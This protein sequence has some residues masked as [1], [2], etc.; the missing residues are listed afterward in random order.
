M[1]Y[2]PLNPG[3]SSDPTA[4]GRAYTPLPNS[5]TRGALLFMGYLG[6]CVCVCVYTAVQRHS[7]VNT[8]PLTTKSK[9]SELAPE[10]SPQSHR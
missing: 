9:A 10:R 6:V 2:F 7:G 4:C 1:D 8:H 3:G 5:N